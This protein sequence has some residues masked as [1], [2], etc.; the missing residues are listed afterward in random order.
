[1]EKNHVTKV[2]KHVHELYLN[3]TTLKEQF[4]TV[5]FTMSIVS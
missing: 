3:S 1:M 2:T 5:R 4:K